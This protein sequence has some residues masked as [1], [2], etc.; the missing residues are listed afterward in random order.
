MRNVYDISLPIDGR[1]PIWPTS[2]GYRVSAAMA[3]AAGDPANVSYLELDVH[4]GTHLEGP[5]HFLPDGAPLDTGDLNCFVGAAMVAE[6]PGPRITPTTLDALALPADTQRLLLK[7]TNSARL[8]AGP[9]GFDPEYVAMTD[10]AASWLVDR[11]LRLVGIDH[12]SVQEY[13]N[14]GETH[15]ILMRGGVTI[16][17]GLDLSAVEP[18]RY[19]LVCLPLRLTGTE[20]A[21]ARAVLLDEAQ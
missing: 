13:G 3:I 1:L 17:E 16:L 6:V 14:D 19:T 2:R 15:R 12:L 4:T 21:P 11:H 9:G 7:T 20:A 18:G 10:A 8:H 5:L